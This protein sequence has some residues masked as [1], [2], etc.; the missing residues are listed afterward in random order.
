MGD[1]RENEWAPPP[2][3]SGTME[4]QSIGAAGEHAERWSRSPRDIKTL[5]ARF[6]GWLDSDLEEIPIVPPGT[7][8]EQ[9]ATY[10]DLRDDTP[11]E[12]TATGGM[13]A[14]SENWYVPKGDV[15]YHTWN[16]LLGRPR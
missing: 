2:V 11:E 16:H 10:I 8:L 9:G 1:I 14:G 5:H 7:R 13:K 3:K 4:G 15:P 12:F 6:Q